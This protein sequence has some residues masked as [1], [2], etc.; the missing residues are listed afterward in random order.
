MTWRVF[1]G[2][3]SDTLAALLVLRARKD[4]LS[5]EPD[6]VAN[7]L[8][9]HLHRG[10]GYLASGKDKGTIESFMSRWTPVPTH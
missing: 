10:L 6:G 2:E 1:A 9:L 5:E 3:Y 8:K 4:G 7:C